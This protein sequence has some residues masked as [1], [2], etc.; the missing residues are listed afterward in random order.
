MLFAKEKG[1]LNFTNHSSYT[2]S[3]QMLVFTNRSCVWVLSG[4]MSCNI[5]ACS[6]K[7]GEMAIAINLACKQ[8]SVCGKLSLCCSILRVDEQLVHSFPLV[9][10]LH[11]ELSSHIYKKSIWSLWQRHFNKMANWLISML[12]FS[13]VS[14]NH[15]SLLETKRK[16][17]STER[18]IQKSCPLQKHQNLS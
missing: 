9:L 6:N 2:N 14:R 10:Q 15:F 18:T 5:P 13:P 17:S 16:K 11:S 4:H 8:F 3:P 1:L 7:W 12:C